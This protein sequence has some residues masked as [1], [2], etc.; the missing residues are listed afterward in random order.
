MFNAL[1]TQS[2]ATKLASKWKKRKLHTPPVS[3]KIKRATWEGNLK[4]SSKLKI[5]ISYDAL[6]VLLV[7]Y[8]ERHSFTHG[9]RYRGS[10]C[11]TEYNIKILV[12][13]TCQ[14]Q[15]R[16]IKCYILT[17]T[18]YI[19]VKGMKY[20]HIHI[21]IKMIKGLRAMVREKVDVE[22]YTE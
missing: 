22:W 8:I 9:N 14:Q 20:T 16:K 4:I 2:H 6:T 7:V 19:E 13:H 1:I 3:V 5:C 12:K 17:E 15:N 10:T 18:C 21:Y 11:N